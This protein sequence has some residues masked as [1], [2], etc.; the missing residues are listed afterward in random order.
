MMEK[1]AKTPNVF[2][3]ELKR[4]LRKILAK[5]LALRA[6]SGVL[7]FVALA[8]WVFVLVILW[9]AVTDAPPLS[10]T[11]AVSR[12]TLLVLGILFATFVVYPI[13][14]TPS[15]R[16]LTF[17]LE[18]RKDFQ[19]LVAAGYEFSQNER[20]SKLYSP[21]LIREVVRQAV[22]SVKG[23]EVRFLFLSRKHLVFVPLAYGAVCVLAV[24]TLATPDTLLDAGKRI[25]VPR[26]ASAVTHE[27]N[28][29]CSPGD[30]TVLSGSD[31]EVTAR[32]FG[33]SEEPVTLSYNLSKEFWKTESTEAREI[34]GGREAISA[35]HVYTFRDIRG[36][37]TYF[38]ERGG[39]QS[40]KFTITV[41]HKP[42]VTTLRMALTPPP[43][44]GE[45][46]D[47]LVDSGGNV[48]VL[49][50][51]HVAVSGTSNNG[52]DAAWVQFDEDEKQPIDIS[53][54][55]FG[56][57]FRALQDGTYSVLLRDSLGHETDDPLV[58][59]VEVFEDRPPVLDVLEPGND[60][61]LPRNLRVNVGFVAADDYGVQKAAVF[62]RRGGDEKYQGATIPLGDD[63]GKREIMKAFVWSLENLTLFPGDYVEYFLQVED[64]NIVTGPGVTKS[65][66]YQIS[67][68][69]MA[70]L[71]ERVEE[72]SAKQTDL[73]DEALKEGRELKERVDK[74]SR[75][76]K[77]TD[78]L[79]WSQKKEIDKAVASQELI[80]DKL[81]EI[82]KSLEETLESLSDNQMTSQQI[83]EKL[84][85]IHRL[86]EEINNEA[87]NKYI[88]EMRKAME[89]LD[90]DQVQQALENLNLSA[91][92]LLRSLERTENLLREIQREQQMEEIIRKTRDLMEAQENLHEMT[93]E[94]EDQDKMNELSV[95]QEALAEETSELEKQLNEF[96]ESLEDPEFG[97]KAKQTADEF[98]MSQ[99]SKKMR[100]AS[101]KLREGRKSQAM[102]DQ[103]QAMDDLIG[104]FGKMAGMQA[105]MQAASGRRVAA[106]LQRLAN[107]TLD[108][109]FKQ[110]KLT[111]ILREQIAIQNSADP[112]TPARELAKDQ[113][114][115]ANAIHQ[116]ADELHA[117]SQS[118]LVVPE[119]LIRS[120]GG[121]LENMEKSMLFLEQNKPFMSVNSSVEATTALNQITMDLLQA[122]ENCSQ[123][124]CGGQP[125][126]S[127]L[128][129]GLLEGQQRMLQQTQELLAMRAAQEKLL[130]EMQAEVDRL[131]GEQRSLK[132]M[133]EQIQKDLK[134]NKRV[135]GRM[136]KIV[137]EMEEVIRDLE[138]G[139]LDEQT[140][141]KEERILSRLLDA[142]RSIH[143][144][145]YEK[146][147]LS[148]TAEDIFSRATGTLS[149]ET[150]SQTLREEIRRAMTLKAPGEFEDLIKLY[151]RVL[152]EEA[153]AARRSE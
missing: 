19:D 25:V 89:K 56:F 126:G 15:L 152:A 108:L 9:T 141:R 153:P 88:E 8:A 90:A 123:G 74:L 58:Y 66:V 42:V 94:T 130:Q 95:D 35:E 68:P 55:T 44:T 53:D 32:D 11:V 41:V 64:N 121:C 24:L 1:D 120:L 12:I 112:D 71:Y 131:A 83:G 73:F 28:L 81:E 140:L 117:I 61:T 115:Y 84:E 62:F 23:L 10:H 109:S 70:E 2:E 92:D 51:T 143:S 82:N 103:E 80:Q 96:S 125:Q 34:P 134:D 136:D 52:L 144:R 72:E 40:P 26:E 147:R 14:R 119:S 7:T 137:D 86:V 124:G 39:R 151:F 36:S 63:A 22:R 102:S 139:V 3:I 128:L 78:Q 133:A 76:M 110:E 135:L 57:D 29:Y 87:L 69:T 122:C 6:S 105:D 43:Y 116:I 59:T 67:V 107:S 111:H 77:K 49:E 138:G 93:G 30:V 75:E 114:T 31:V 104:L 60:A 16:R 129:Q 5:T 101:K 50:G 118:S 149:E 46:A 98:S 13:A 45:P 48:H 85:E 106:N 33:G 99:T 145:D 97:E 37:V 127:P 21:E 17:E 150:T 148:V 132:D 20:A 142:Q 47:T 27:A 146:K 54:R 79:D 38:F 65:R 4:E 113:Q 91:E 18:N 100:N